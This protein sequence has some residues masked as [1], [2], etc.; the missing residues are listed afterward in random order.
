MFFAWKRGWG[1]AKVGGAFG[2]ENARVRI[3]TRGA[4]D[5]DAEGRFQLAGGAA[6]LPA[7]DGA[8]LGALQKGNAMTLEVVLAT[9]DLRQSGPARIVSFSEDGYHRNFTLGQERNRLVLRLRAKGTD[10]NGRDLEQTFGEVA[11]GR[12]YHV[13]VTYAP[14]DLRA[15]VDGREVLRTDR[16]KG[17]FSN[18]APMHF[19]LGDEWSDT[20]DWKGSLSAVGIWPRA[21]TAEEIDERSTFN[22][23]RSTLK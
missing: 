11:A 20:R 13:V 21:L 3:V 9:G 10:E 18:W 12:E 19:V 16:I 7:L 1:K 22:V 8:L 6:Y 2:S 4:A 5:I 14:G 17:D 23:Q 15:Y